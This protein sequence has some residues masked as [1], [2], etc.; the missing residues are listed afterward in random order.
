MRIIQANGID[1]SL[2]QFDFDLTWAVLFM[3][4]DQTIYGRYGSRTQR[5]GIRDISVDGFARA[6]EAALSLHKNYPANKQLFAGNV[7]PA[8]K[9]KTPE[10]YPLLKGKY[11]ATLET[12]KNLRHSCMHCHQIL[13]AERQT[14]REARKPLADEE[15]WR[16]PRPEVLGMVI[17]HHTRGTI[18]TV[19]PGTAAAK[20]GLKIKDE[21]QRVAGVPITSIADLQWILE[22]TKDTRLT[23][24]IQRAGTIVELTLE[25]PDGWRRHGDISW[26]TS[27]WDLR[28]MAAGGLVL[29]DLAASDRKKLGVDSD[30]LALRVK[31]VGQFGAHA[32]AKNAGFKVGDVLIDFDG[33][34]ARWSESDFLAYGVQKKLPGER[35]PVTVL[36][37][38]MK[39]E[40]VLGMQ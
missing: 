32:V 3:N 10:S 21:V 35:V 38:G 9:Y 14:I 39:V 20:A 37:G 15:L 18:T 33:Q 12:G 23:V 5:D 36:R 29:E 19:T 4:P 27:T 31:H 1:L 6:M 26:R 11:Q 40:M 2:C 25:L 22:R 7:H 13:A 24:E 34:T 17:D 8:P 16:F 28:R 30:K